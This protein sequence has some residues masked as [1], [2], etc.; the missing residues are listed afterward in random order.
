MLF[1]TF[2]Q[3]LQ[4]GDMTPRQPRLKSARASTD[5]THA[6]LISDMRAI[7]IF[8]NALLKIKEGT[9]LKPVVDFLE[10]DK[11]KSLVAKLSESKNIDL[12]KAEVVSN[13]P[14]E[15]QDTLSIAESEIRQ[16]P[17]DNVISGNN[18]PKNQPTTRSN[19][20]SLMD[21]AEQDAVNNPSNQQEKWRKLFYQM[22]IKLKP[23]DIAV[24]CRLFEGVI[25]GGEIAAWL[26]RS[27][28][29]AEVN[30]EQLASN[31]TEACAIGQELV[32]CGLL[33]AVCSGFIDE[34]HDMHHFENEHEKGA[35]EAAK[36]SDMPGHIYRFPLKSGTA[37]SW[38][39]FGATIS[40]KIPTMTVADE[41]DSKAT[42]DTVVLT[43]DNGLLA[44]TELDANTPSNA[45]TGGHVKYVID[46]THGDDKWQ[47]AR[48]YREFEQLHK[49]LLK[50]GVR[51][52]ANVSFLL[53][54][55]LS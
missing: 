10:L 11:A 5:F 37:G 50:E 28:S 52:D 14:S 41:S 7:T 53:V 38:S 46:I 40:V 31:R 27:T 47:T 45:T 26:I 1:P 48:R 13:R 2:F 16:K 21:V 39:I 18:S 3:V 54:K 32:T 15:N 44:D 23:H 43:I 42:R 22:R 19:V 17:N 8:L 24:R 6:E 35:E 20:Q 30:V 34:D 36:F 51:P 4:L 33:V 9:V 29:V 12:E 49:T 25:S 55:F